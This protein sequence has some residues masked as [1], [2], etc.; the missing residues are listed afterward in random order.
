MLRHPF[1]RAVAVASVLAL[2]AV[3]CGGDDDSSAADG[4]P[5]VDAAEDTDVS[6]GDSSDSADSGDAGDSDDSGDSA[7]SG[8]SADDEAGVGEPRRGGTFVWAVTGGPS[9][10]NAAVRAGT[11]R[12]IPSSQIHASLVTIDDEFQPEPYLAESFESSDDQLT[13]TFT[14]R[15]AVFHDGVPV[16]SDDVAFS[17]DVA[18]EFNPYR[19]VYA[20]ITVET[21][22]ERTVVFDLAQPIPY[23]PLVL[24]SPFLP[25]LP[26]HVYGDGQDVSTHPRNDVDIVGAGPF[27]VTEFELGQEL[28]L[29]RFD[30]FFIEG[31][32]YFDEIIMVLAADPST[33]LLRLE[34]GEIDL[35]TVTAAQDQERARSMPN[36][37]VMESAPVDAR[38]ITDV[39]VFNFENEF[40]ANKDVRQ[41]IAY[42]IDADFLV[43]VI[44]GGAGERTA[45]QIP[46]RTPF[47][48]PTVE[49]YDYDPE[50]AARMLDEAGFPEVNGTRFSL[51]IIFV[52]S[53]APDFGSTIAEFVSTQ[54]AEVGIDVTVVTQPDVASYGQALATGDFDMAQALPF[55]WGDPAIGTHR[56]YLTEAIVPAPGF[57][58]SRYSNPEVDDILARAAV[59]TDV[60]VRREL[61]AE[62]QQIVADELPILPLVTLPVTNF[63]NKRVEGYPQGV[64]INVVPFDGAWL[65]E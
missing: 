64:W 48:D 31:R 36:V 55:M 12:S 16:T 41:A 43:E 28:R 62:F 17:V 24:S 37:T 42:A 9:G 54:L 15:D 6:A 4:Q 44:Q 26:K 8:N 13:W 50:R 49:T 19:H 51:D 40:L 34:R 63:I 33:D 45:S 7:D 57:N 46:P 61:Y 23:L 65:A 32:P 18:K 10:T 30:E 22:D 25:I 27:R 56:F 53:I 11:S 59:E 47:H 14:L 21:P 52:Q 35:L 39:I 29:E 60:E 1:R 3:A 5:T 20:P 58:N 38:G 2:A